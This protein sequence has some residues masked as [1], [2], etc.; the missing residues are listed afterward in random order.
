MPS[1]PFLQQLFHPDVKSRR[2]PA[3]FPSKLKPI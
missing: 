3:G 1:R 2:S